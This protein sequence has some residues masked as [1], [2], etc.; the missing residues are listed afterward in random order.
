MS[1]PPCHDTS[2]SPRRPR[3]R[4]SAA[5]RDSAHS[6]QL[7]R[8]PLDAK[9]HGGVP[10]VGEPAEHRIVQAARRVQ[11]AAH[12]ADR[13]RAEAAW[14]WR[15]RAITDSG[16]PTRRERSACARVCSCRCTA[17]SVKR[18]GIT[19]MGAEVDASQPDYDAAHDAALACCGAGWHGLRE[20]VHRPFAA[21]R[22]RA[23]WDSR[24]SKTSRACA[25]SSFQSAVAGSPGGSRCSFAPSRRTSASSERRAS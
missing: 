25:R 12:D 1:D 20:P 23:P 9:R 16:S 19:A 8:A 18:D 14:W 15:R 5:R 3:G 4:A 24:F 11:R 10:Q 7:L 6:V 21:R 2:R 13:G 17:P 22:V